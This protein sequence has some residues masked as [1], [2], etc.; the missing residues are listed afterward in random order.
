M[1]SKAIIQCPA[2]GG[3][4]WRLGEAAYVR[5]VL[6]AGDPN[7]TEDRGVVRIPC[8]NCGFV[9]LFEAQTLGVRGLWDASRDL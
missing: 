8:G 2:C 4:S 1:R 3:N 5:G 9:M 6:E 7:L